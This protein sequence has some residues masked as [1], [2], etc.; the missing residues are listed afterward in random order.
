MS[1]SLIF[2]FIIVITHSLL[3]TEMLVKHFYQ[4]HVHMCYSFYRKSGLSVGENFVG[5]HEDVCSSVI[6]H[7]WDEAKAGNTEILE[8][9]DETDFTEKVN[10]INMSSQIVYILHIVFT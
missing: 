8:T 7:T 3:K 4:N 1:Y 5:Y 2:L 9:N 10:I 6:L